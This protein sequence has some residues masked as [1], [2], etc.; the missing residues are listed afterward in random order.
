VALIR[1]DI[2]LKLHAGWSYQPRE[3][4]TIAETVAL[5]RLGGKVDKAV[6]RAGFG[7]PLRTR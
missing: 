2:I 1:L 5:R 3:V 7:A 6:G 4:A